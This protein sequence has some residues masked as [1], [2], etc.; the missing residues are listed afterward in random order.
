MAGLQSTLLHGLLRAC[1]LLH[2]SSTQHAATGHTQ[3]VAAA[4]ASPVGVEESVVAAATAACNVWAVLRPRWPLAFSKSPSQGFPLPPQQAAQPIP[5]TTQQ[6]LGQAQAELGFWTG[7]SF[8]LGANSQVV[9]L[10]LFLSH[11]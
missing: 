3:P 7:P 6:V 2:P 9:F 4:G 10:L 1:S 11:R 5:Q 8:L